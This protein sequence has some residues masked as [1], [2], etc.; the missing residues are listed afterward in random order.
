VRLDAFYITLN[1]WFGR[2]GYRLTVWIALACAWI[3]GRGRLFPGLLEIENRS[4]E[5]EQLEIP[6]RRFRWRRKRG[7]ADFHAAGP[8]QDTSR[9]VE[10]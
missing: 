5:S 1:K 7:G 4:A 8:V 9:D 6:L 2:A 3:F 10:H